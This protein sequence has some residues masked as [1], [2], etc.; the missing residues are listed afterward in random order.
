MIAWETTHSSV[1]KRDSDQRWA[2]P[3]TAVRQPTRLKQ[4][5]KPASVLTALLIDC[6]IDSCESE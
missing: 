3:L 2:G 1:K 6:T 4:Q 5:G